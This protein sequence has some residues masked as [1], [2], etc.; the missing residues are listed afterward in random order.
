[1]VH[2]PVSDRQKILFI[3]AFSAVL[4]IAGISVFAGGTFS[5]VLVH[6]CI[7]IFFG[8]VLTAL[9]YE[10]RLSIK[11]SADTEAISHA[12][13]DA[14]AD[15]AMLID[16]FE[17]ILGIN[18]AG[19]LPLGFPKHDLVGRTLEDVLRPEHLTEWR[20]Y[21][22][23]AILLGQAQVFNSVR[24]DRQ[25]ENRVYPIADSNGV[26][27]RLGL[28]KRDITD[29]IRSEQELRDNRDFLQSVI[30]HMP[31]TMFV[32]DAETRQ[33][34]IWNKYAESLY[35]IPA[36]EIL[37][38]LDEDLFPTHEAEFFRSTDTK[39][40]EKGEII[41]IPEETV[42][43]R[44]HGQIYIHTIKVPVKDERDST[45]Y[46]LGFSENVTERRRAFAELKRSEERL[47]KAQEA[48]NIGSWEL[49]LKTKK[50]WASECS[51][52][53]YGVEVTPDFCVT[54]SDAQD[55]VHPHDRERMD[56]AL[57]D[58][59]AD[60]T[61]YD[62][63]YKINRRSDGETRIMHSRAEL[64][65]D[66]NGA[67][68]KVIGTLQD[69]TERKMLEHQLIQAQ[70]LEGIG[71]LAGGIAHDFNNLLA[72]VLGTAELLKR[73]LLS[74]PDLHRHIDR[75]IETTHRGT[76]I[77]RQLLVFSRQD[78]A[79]LEAISLS[80]ILTEVHEMML[81]FLP[82]D[83]TV[84]V[85]I[86]VQ[87]GLIMGDSGYI[88]QALMN[89]AIN[90]RD[91]MTRGGTLTF[92]EHSV[93]ASRL[94]SRFPR[95]EDGMYIAVS[96]SDTG[97]GMSEEVRRKIFDPFFTTKDRGKGTGLGLA[98]VHSIVQSH[99][100]FIDVQSELGNG[101]T[102]TMY[103]P[104]LSQR[105]QPP[106]PAIEPGEGGHETILLVDD[107]DIIREMLEEHLLDQG[108]AVMTASNGME[109]LEKFSAHGS[110]IDLVIT[111][112]GMPQ[113]DG[114]ALFARL[115]AIDPAVKV[116]IS[117]GYLDNSSKND[118]LAKGVK[119]VLTKPYKFSDIQRSIR[120]V[121]DRASAITTQES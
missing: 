97:S 20:G 63:E 51:F 114:E 56:L 8:L 98:I 55:L 87:N 19:A 57:N 86:Q 9:L 50:M 14:S 41:D 6:T 110:D 106:V 5:Q 113:M 15:A 60:G 119:D 69:I 100:G 37:G 118:M 4:L 25:F 30:D 71:T 120:T 102:F 77:T 70:K 53:L 32:K 36:A 65:R 93:D 40:L 22:S 61:Y 73:K 88:H 96:V 64:L 18:D 75:I 121:L 95:I 34:L 45:R 62:V 52:M 54:L 82:K 42:Q 76:S 21:L 79:E 81:H 7:I 33:F 10:R 91:A 59:L 103:F 27:V 83:I 111:D 107:E 47:R 12:L 29:Q 35:G 13:L 74:S 39:M 16:R 49:D 17:T 28:Y 67:P 46:I 23:Q 38:K 108:Y 104:A 80:H 117:S 89:L 101:T 31:V 3:L 11:T 94:R 2:S 116:I 48:A 66:T 109:A 85:D 105:L 44:S 78:F 1:M 26:V 68:W 90:A 112:L 84:H 24:G 72:M 99:K 43:S 115:S 58:L 92:A